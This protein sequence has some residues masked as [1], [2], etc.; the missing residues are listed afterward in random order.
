MTR[1]RLAG[2]A[3]LAVAIVAAALFLGSRAQLRTDM[4]F[5]LPRSPSADTRLLLDQMQRGPTANLLLVRLSGAKP[6]ALAEISDRM[7]KA[8]RR[9]DRFAFAAN[10]SAT[11]DPATLTWITRYRYL[12][13]PPIATAEFETAALRKSLQAAAASMATTLGLATKETLGAD[14][15]GR[16]VRVGRHLAGSGGPSL[17]HGVWFTPD[18][19]G[20]LIVVRTAASGLEIEAQATAITAVKAAFD[21]AKATRSDTAAAIIELT[22]SGVFALAIRDTSKR[23]LTVLSA[24][25]SL[26]VL[27][28]LLLAVRSITTVALFAVILGTAIGTG[29]VAVQLA[30]GE[31]HAVTL[32]FGATLMG[33]AIDYPLHV[34]AHAKGRAGVASAAAHVGPTLRLSAVTTAAAFVPFALSSFP[35][36]AQLGVMSIVGLLAAAAMSRWIL[37]LIAPP[38]R[39]LAL[40]SWALA[41]VFDRLARPKALAAAI[42]VLFLGTAGAA[43]AFKLPV[44][45]D[46]LTRLSPLPQSQVRL[47][48]SIRSALGAP[49]PRHMVLLKGSSPESVL[50]ASETATA[51]LSAMKAKGVLTGF[52][53]PSR[54]LPSAASQARRQARLPDETRLKENLDAALPGLPF[55]PAAFGAFLRDVE[56]ARRGTVADRNSTRG[57]LIAARIDP[58]LFQAGDQ[59]FGLILL[60][61]VTEPIS[62]TAE[63]ARLGATG[64]RL[65]DLK[66][67]A[68][69]LARNYRVE[70]LVLLGLSAVLILVI[71]ALSR[72]RMADIV[73]VFLP[74]LLSVGATAVVLV[75]TGAA[76]SVFH[77]MSLFV[78]AGIGLDYA[79][80]LRRHR[81]TADRD[82]TRRSVLL[83]S[84]TTIVVYSILATSALPI[85]HGIGLTIAIGTGFAV[86]L[87]SSFVG[88]WPKERR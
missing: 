25:A 28:I 72:Q 33:L 41:T 66:A 58:L 15:T 88:L 22:G 76:L 42:G 64:A 18:G 60:S 74:V 48:Q 7:V 53:P 12:L 86:L 24:A 52:D 34:L 44:W 61:G 38:A 79:L 65:I 85:L 50:R 39:T 87:A 8:L 59:W 10:G 70:T 75:A 73:V 81:Q 23:D 40:P 36:L 2:L 82:N 17:R 31:I 11:L 1:A 62:K 27:V 55:R 4:G 78:V 13:N 35:V 49:N 30:F 84:L 26:A 57:T 19:A 51:A 67:E 3:L 43:I 47:D 77:L 9:D 45:Q 20:A 69:A 71:L 16:I 54:Y 32:T 80:F 14:P 46:E 56:V 63:T 83:C 68:D 6:P 29:A 37:P 5:L 21:A